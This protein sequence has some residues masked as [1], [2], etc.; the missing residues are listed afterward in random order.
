MTVGL[1]TEI[2][3]F[4]FYEAWLLDRGDYSEWLRLTAPSI[5]YWAPVREDGQQ[6]GEAFVRSETLA[7]FDDDHQGLAM[8]VQRFNGDHVHANSPPARVR[9]LISNVRVLREADDLV[10]VTSNF[11]CFKSR[12]SEEKVYSGRRD[13]RLRRTPGGWLIEERCIV[14]DHSVV[15]SLTTLY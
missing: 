4:L 3:D 8:R 11:L 14:F 2:E 9:H 10:E 6:P 7:H 1:R 5:R 13:D 12:L 15:T